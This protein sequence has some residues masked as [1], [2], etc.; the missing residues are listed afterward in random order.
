PWELRQPCLRLLAKAGIAGRDACAPRIFALALLALFALPLLAFAQGSE[1][2]VKAK[3]YASADGVRPGDKFKIAVALE[4]GEGYHINAHHPSLDYLI[5][6]AIKFEP[7]AGMSIG[8]EKYPGP[9]HRKFEFA[10]DTELAVHEG[11]LFIT[12]EVQ[13][14][15]TLKPGS[16]TVRGLVTVHACNDSQC[17]APSDLTVEVPIKVVAATQPVKDANAE[18][19]AKAAAQPDAPESS[20][21]LV[22]YGGGS[23]D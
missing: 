4:V 8:P 5:A 19:F 3:G 17:L 22:Q 1:R 20:G 7:V 12:A 10:P 21:S 2:V 11:T 14:D 15:K 16:M 18:I 13:A 23:K 9:K 6:T